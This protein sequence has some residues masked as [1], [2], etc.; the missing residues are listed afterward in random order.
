MCRQNV[1]E[2]EH[3]NQRSLKFRST[4]L[5]VRLQN[6]NVIAACLW[7]ST[8]ALSSYMTQ[9]ENVSGV[10]SSF[11]CILKY[12]LYVHITLSLS[13]A[14][15]VIT[16][17]AAEMIGVH[18]GSSDQSNI[19][20]LIRTSIKTWRKEGLGSV[21][22]SGVA[23]KEVQICYRRELDVHQS[24]YLALSEPSTVAIQK[25]ITPCDPTS[26]ALDLQI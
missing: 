6:R 8:S 26:P 1:L 13:L 16:Y 5:S 22:E 9:S 24:H 14:P 15:A 3:K 18:S 10:P 11:R 17:L 7:L 23:N 25:A 20:L 21:K 12:L 19:Q 2:I 4:F